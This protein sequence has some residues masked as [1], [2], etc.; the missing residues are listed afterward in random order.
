[1]AR[2]KKYIISTFLHL[3][4]ILVSLIVLIP[5][6]W[7]VISSFNASSGLASATLIPEK[8]TVNNYVKLFTE[9]KYV[10]WFGN[11]LKIAI[12][13]SAVSVMIV[14]VTAWV[15]SRFNFKGKKT[16]LMTLLILSMFPSFLSMTAIYVLFLTFGLL[17]KPIALVLIYS[18]GAIPYNVWLVK[19]YLDGVSKSLDE[20]A[21]IDGCT[22]LKAFFKVT[23]PL[24]MPIVT[25]VAVTQF[26]APWMD[27]I[28]PNLLLSKDQNRTLAVGL[29]ALISE[30]E[31]TGFT[32]FAAGAVLVAVPI[33]I[34]YII[35][36]KY[37]VQGIS[38]GANKE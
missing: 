38:A 11:T 28:L 25:Y 26:M 8:L 9:T 33:S 29:Y 17:N 12:V 15:M 20:A 24:S 1:M 4:L 36:Q 16:G 32:M 19:G 27:Y 3:E 34:V 14:M 21:Y 23:L 30:Q 2:F 7:I 5:I 10:M 22:R 31:S 18:V 35:F 13:N 6:F 37:I